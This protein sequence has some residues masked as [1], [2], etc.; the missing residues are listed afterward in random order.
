MTSRVRAVCYR[1]FGVASAFT[2]LSVP[3][4]V[5]AQWGKLEKLSGA[6]DWQGVI[7]EFRVACFGETTPASRLT[8]DARLAIQ[9]AELSRNSNDPDSNEWQT[10]A[11]G[12]QRA[13]NAWAQV[14][15]ETFKPSSLPGRGAGNPKLAADARTSAEQSEKRARAMLTSTSSAGVLWSL[16]PSD[17]D[18]RLSID[19]GWSTWDAD[20]DPGYAGGARINLDML[21][22]LVSWR[23]LADTNFDFVELS[24]GAGMYW[25]SSTGFES[26]RGV[27]LQPARLT[28]RA[29]SS[30]S[31]STRIWR[32]LA[33]IPV[34]GFGVTMFPDGFEPNDF[35]GV[36][37]KA[38]RIPREL[39]TTHYFFVNVEPFVQWLRK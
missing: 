3:A 35:A 8:R 20:P 32:R 4:P 29:P 37:D 19:I 23:V 7:Y 33:A 31:G 15:G 2:L 10:A 27:V 39:L 12:W 24:A 17:K 25:F 13:A 11:E 6:G 5:Y 18:R 34:Y 22:P 21:M 30:W 16:C 28:L 1:A 14:L 9:A 26:L 38:V 36:G